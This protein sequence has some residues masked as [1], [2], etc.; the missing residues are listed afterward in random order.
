MTA[1]FRS[2]RSGIDRASRAFCPNSRLLPIRNTVKTKRNHFLMDTNSEQNIQRDWLTLYTDSHTDHRYEHTPILYVHTYI[3]SLIDP[4]TLIYIYI[5]IYTYTFSF[6]FEKCFLTKIHH[7][8]PCQHLHFLDNAKAASSFFSFSSRV[9][10]PVCFVKYH[11]A[12]R[13]P[14]CAILKQMRSVLLV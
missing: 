2:V 4:H 3:S 9:P 7:A 11:S 5:Y 1:R 12:S 14:Y 10:P 13:D 6:F 8:H